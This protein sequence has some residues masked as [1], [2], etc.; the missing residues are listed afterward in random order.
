MGRLVD[1]PPAPLVPF[2]KMTR[3]VAR[4]LES[5]GDGRRLRIEKIGHPAAMVLLSRGEIAVDTEPGRIAPRGDGD[6]RRRTDRRGDVELLELRSVPSEGVDI[7]G[8]EPLVSIAT[9]VAVAH[10]VDVDEEDVGGGGG[11]AG[12]HGGEEAERDE[13]ECDGAEK[14]DEG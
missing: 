8:G 9:Q 10:I 12:R 6:A 14:K 3:G 11:L 2:S 4:L 1:V 13:Q 5:P 7:R